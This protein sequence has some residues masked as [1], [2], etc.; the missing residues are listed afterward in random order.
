MSVKGGLIESWLKKKR[1]F[2]KEADLKNVAA[3]CRA[4]LTQNE[5]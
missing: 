3:V 5:F 4:T 2:K 1:M